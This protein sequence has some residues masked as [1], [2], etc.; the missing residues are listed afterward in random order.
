MPAAFRRNGMDGCMGSFDG[1]PESHLPPPKIWEADYSPNA[2]G[3]SQAY[4]PSGALQMGGKRARAVG[5]LR[6]LVAGRSAM[7]R[8]LLGTGLA[9]TADGLFRRAAAARAGRNRHS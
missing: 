5:R 8:R 7:I 1:V 3:T 9:L 4:L 2:T 6:G